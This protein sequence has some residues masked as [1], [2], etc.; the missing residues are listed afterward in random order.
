MRRGIVALGLAVAVI[1]CKANLEHHDG[2]A[3]TGGTTAG[4]GGTTAGTGGATPG[5]G[6]TTAG[7]GGATPGTGGTT[8]GTGGATAGTGGTTVGT[9][10]STVGTGGAAGA[11]GGMSGSGGVAGGSPGGSGGSGGSGGAAPACAQAATQCSGTG[12]QTCG[13]D[14]TWGTTKACDSAICLGTNCLPKTAILISGGTRLFAYDA[15]TGAFASSFPYN[16]SFLEGVTLGPDGKLWGVAVDSKTIVRYDLSGQSLGIFATTQD[17]SDYLAFGPDGN[18]YVSARTSPR[19]TIVRFNATTSASMGTFVQGP[20]DYPVSGLVFQGQ[21]LFVT[22]SGSGAVGGSLYQYSATT[23]ALVQIVYDQFAPYG[24][25]TPAFA[26]DGNMYVPIWQTSDVAKFDATTLTFIS[27][28]S[29]NNL[30]ATSIAVT[31]AGK[32][33]I[34]SDPLGG[35]DSVQ[36]FDPKAGTFSTLVPTGS[37]GVGRATTIIYR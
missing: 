25:E 27:N 6:G 3:G 21:S 7:T 20:L 22:Y 33:L 15:Q 29:M 12:V 32:L 18:L 4:T 34:L 11:S 30:N 31:P 26:L 5:T 14:G 23:G 16:E 35:S 24:P 13:A 17:Y 36:S 28:I 37:G 1:S 8:L 19:T 10:G 9:G 2:P